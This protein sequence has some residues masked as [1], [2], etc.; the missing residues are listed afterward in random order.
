MADEDKHREDGTGKSVAYFLT[1]FFGLLLLSAT[2]FV[3]F[4]CKKSSYVPDRSFIVEN[5]KDEHF[6]RLLVERK[7][8]GCFS[9]TKIIIKIMKLFKYNVKLGEY[10]LPNRVSLF[11]A[12]EIIDS[13]KVVVHKITIPEG[14]SVMQVI[15]RL[16]KDENLLGAIIKIPQEG[17]LLPDT[18]CFKYPTTRQEIISWAR[19]AMREFM[20]REWPKRSLTCKLSNSHEA[21]TL[22]SII[23]KETN[24]ERKKIAGVYMKRLKIGMRLQACP[25]VI[26]ALKKGD[27]LGRELRYSD[28]IVDDPFN[29]Y[30][31][32]GL[33]P[34]PITNPGRESILAVLHPEETEELFFVHRGN[35]YHAF[36]KTY[37]EHKKN[38]A[39]FRHISTRQ[40]NL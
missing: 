20:H 19:Q 3:F 15:R 13:G 4:L 18:Y 34:G 31:H 29:T 8:A 7:V 37:R 9:M 2:F 36:A 24:S 10:A 23:E 32:N 35:G 39:R 40:N 16:E 28:L 6:S 21:V 30:M 1:G 22:A 5:L 12:L 26:Y 11:E 27:V 33:P 38:I 17:S 25:T 14:F